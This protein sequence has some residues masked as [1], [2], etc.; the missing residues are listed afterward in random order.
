[1]KVPGH[2]FSG[3][4]RAHDTLC[5]LLAQ[6]VMGTLAAGEPRW[7]GTFIGLPFAWRPWK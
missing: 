5:R 7:Q 1:M 6:G 4:Q 3:R 2:R